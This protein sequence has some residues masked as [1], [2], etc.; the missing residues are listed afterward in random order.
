MHDNACDIERFMPYNCEDCESAME[1]LC[2]FNQNQEPMYYEDDFNWNSGEINIDENGEHGACI[3]VNHR[4]ERENYLTCDCVSLYDACI[5]RGT[6]VQHS[7]CPQDDGQHIFGN[8]PIWNS[9]EP[10]IDEFTS[11]YFRVLVGDGVCEVS[12]DC[13]SSGNWPNKYDNREECEIKVMREA[14]YRFSVPF[15]LESGYDTLMIGDRYVEDSDWV[16]WSYEVEP[17]YIAEDE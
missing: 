11:S 13:V 6:C 4:Y 16:A 17:Y 14:V 15:Q 8:D 7:R 3:H 5:S 10:I 12:G 2:G 9:L 1:D